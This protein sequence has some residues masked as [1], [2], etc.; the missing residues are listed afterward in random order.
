[1]IF[2]PHDSVLVDDLS[3]RHHRAF[4]IAGTRLRWDTVP[5]F[6]QIGSLCTDA[7]VDGQEGEVTAELS[8][9]DAATG[10]TAGR[11]VVGIDHAAGAGAGIF[12]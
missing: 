8:E 11:D 7:A 9:V 5:R 2:I 6:I 3:R 4:V 12:T 10:A 1:M